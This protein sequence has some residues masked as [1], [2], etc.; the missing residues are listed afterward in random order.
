M[1]YL[2]FATGINLP[3][4]WRN[5]E[6]LIEGTDKEGKQAI[7]NGKLFQDP[8]SIKWED[9]STWFD[10]PLDPVISISGKN[11]IIK[12]N[13][14]K[15][16]NIGNR[17]G[18]IKEIWSQ[19]DYEIEIAGLLI[20]TEGQ[21]PEDALYQLRIYLEARKPLEVVG[22]LFSLFNISKIAIE[23]YSLPFTKSKENQMYNIKAVSDDAFDLLVKG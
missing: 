19:D 11:N 1:I 20:G 2:N 8:L 10:F 7:A 18:S 12:R 17:R 4:Y 15:I 9:E 6:V 21:F 13:V 3:P 5:H 23:S 16:N 22:E 14:L